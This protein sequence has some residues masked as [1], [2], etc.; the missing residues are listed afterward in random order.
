MSSSSQAVPTAPKPPYPPSTAPLGGIPT[1]IPDIPISAALVG[2]FGL[3]A[4]AHLFLFGRNARRGRRFVFSVLLG[5]FSCV[6]MAALALRVAWA[7]EPANANVA[8]AATVLTNAGVLILFIVN[9]VLAL[10]VVRATHPAAGWSR[11]AWWGFRGLVATVVAVLV[12]VVTCSVHS[13]F[14]LDAR[15]RRMERDVLLFAGVYMTFIALLPAIA[16]VLAV[17][18]PRRGAYP[19]EKFGSGSMAAKMVLLAFTST[20][21]AVGAGFRAAVNF[22]AKPVNQP[23]WYHSRPA[24]YCFIFAI[25]IVVVYTYLFTRFDKRFYVPPGSSA[26]GDYSAAGQQ[27]PGSKENVMVVP[28]YMN[29]GLY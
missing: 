18:L 11:V 5:V 10:R 26:P 21:L 29:E 3:A 6:R 19:A 27:Q 28:S 1:P 7:R 14:T 4:L 25:E 23:Q 12:M 15:A 8:L 16:V 20:L 22:A 9:L 24:F 2:A 13:V 17:V